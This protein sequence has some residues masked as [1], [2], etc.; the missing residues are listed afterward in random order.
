[1]NALSQT[2]APLI[3][4]AEQRV[5]L[6]DVSWEMYERMLADLRLHPGT[7]LTYD[8]GELEIMVVSFKHEKVSSYLNQFV[9]IMAVEQKKDF[10]EGRST[11]FKRKGSGKGFEPDGCYYFRNVGLMRVKDEIDLNKDPAPDLAIEVDI[12]SPSLSRFPIFARLGVA[13]IWR[14]H[15]GQ[16]EFFQL[17]AATCLR[18]KTSRF[19]PR[20]A[21]LKVT[22]LLGQSEQL[23][24]Y[25]WQEKVRQYARQL[26]PAAK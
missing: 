23:P 13:E 14:Y 18:R 26:Q 5:L 11:T 10:V 3:E 8:E 9:Q 4:G 12:T 17:R 20:V 22:E 6:Y 1:M 21:S 25:E 7:R 16:V 2:V 19:L 24:V 15:K